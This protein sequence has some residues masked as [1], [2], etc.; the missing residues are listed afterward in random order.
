MATRQSPI[1]YEALVKTTGFTAG[2]IPTPDIFEEEMAKIFHRG[3]VYV[4][5][6]A[7]SRG[8]ATFG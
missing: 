8:R 6:A 2:C 7:K 1:D 4:G 5:H 3:W